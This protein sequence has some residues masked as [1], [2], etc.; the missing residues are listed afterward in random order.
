V[1]AR[2]LP[3]RNRCRPQPFPTPQSGIAG[4]ALQPSFEF[5]GKG[6][7]PQDQSRVLPNGAWGRPAGSNPGS[8][9]A[10]SSSRPCL[11]ANDPERDLAVVE[12]AGGGH[13]PEDAQELV[14]DR[15]V[16]LP[17]LHPVA[18]ARGEDEEALSE[19]GVVGD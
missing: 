16:G 2:S 11:T 3:D 13:R 12:A 7:T 15:H 9:R 6:G 17:L 4:S 1:V 5:C 19:V 18:L 8:E 14:G 10:G